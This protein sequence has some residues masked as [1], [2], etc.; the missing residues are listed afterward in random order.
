MKSWSG[1]NRVLRFLKTFNQAVKKPT[2]LVGLSWGVG[3][4]DYALPYFS[5]NFS[6]DMQRYM[7]NSMKAITAGINV[8]QKIR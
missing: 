8:Q 3:G 1:K 2:E 5:A 4:T 7:M 6:S